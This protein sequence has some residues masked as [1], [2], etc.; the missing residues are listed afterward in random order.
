MTPPKITGVLETAIHVCDMKRAEDF[1]TNVMGFR[2][3]D[4]SERFCAFDVGGRD[5]FLLFRSG[6]SAEAVQLP[7]GLIPP[8]GSS[9]VLH[10]AFPI[11]DADW[12]S[13]VKYLEANRVAIESVVR[14]PRG[15]RSLYFRDPDNHLV[16]LATPGLWQNY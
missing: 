3:M 10:F 15:G 1:Y 16:E 11:A 8:H 14:W 7:G 12:D 5:V 4:G 13:W 6:G 2:K 9:G